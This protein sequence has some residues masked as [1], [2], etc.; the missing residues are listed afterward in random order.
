MSD[1]VKLE[2]VEA[3]FSL[4]QHIYDVLRAAITQI[5]IY[6]DEADL[7]LDERSLADQLGISR[8]PVREALA[9]LQQDGLVE[10]APRKGVFVAR[11]SLD[12]ILEMIIVWAALEGMAARLAAERASDDALAGLRAQAAKYSVSAAGADIAEYSEGNIQFHRRILELSGCALLLRSADALFVHM[13][14]VRKR[15]MREGDRIS[16][17]V[18][19]HLGIIEAL[20]ARA[21]DAAAERVREHTMRLHDHVRGTWLAMQSARRKEGM[22]AE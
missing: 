16:R 11:K 1:V 17:S 7:R 4:K 14:A 6:D 2:P 15:A 5:D 8:T 12:E 22:V 9:R 13:H 3:S 20:E 21:P 10:I 19:D 18:V